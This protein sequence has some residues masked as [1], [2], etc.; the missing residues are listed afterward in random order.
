VNKG[1]NSGDSKLNFNDLR[2]SGK[3]MYSSVME[4]LKRVK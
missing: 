4:A 2:S 1:N 3:D